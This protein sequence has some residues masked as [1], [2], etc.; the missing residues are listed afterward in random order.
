MYEHAVAR[1]DRLDELDLDRRA[2]A[3]LVRAQ[4]EPAGS[5][6]RTTRI[7]TPSSPH[8]TQWPS[9]GR[10]VA[11]SITLAFSSSSSCS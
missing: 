6:T 5:S 8:V 2:L 1:R 9:G 10:A 3:V 11:H 7:G 4:R